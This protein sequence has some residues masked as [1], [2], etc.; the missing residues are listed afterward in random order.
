MGTIS[1]TLSGTPATTST[2]STPTYFAGVSTYSTQLQE[3]IGRAV[4]IASLPIQELTSQQTAL[5]GQATELTTLD[6]DFAAVQTAIQNISSA[7]GGA[8]MNSTVSNPA[9]ASVTVGD[10]ATQGEYSLDV[11]SIGAY[12][13]SLTGG[14]W[15]D[16]TDPKGQ[17]T[18][19]NLVVGANTHSFTPTDNSAETVAATINAQ[20]GDVVQATAV[21]VGSASSPDERISLQSV[22]LGPMDLDIQTPAGSSLQIAQPAATGYA[23][24]TSANTWDS[25]GSPSTY[26][27][28]VDGADYT[29]S[30][31]DNSAAQVAAAINAVSGNPVQASVVNLGTATSP[32]ERIQLQSTSAGVATVDLLDSSGNSLQ[33]QETPAAA[34]SAVSQTSGTWDSTPDPSGNPTQYILTVGSTTQTFTS[35]DTSATGVAAAINAL[36]GNPV[37]ATVV[38]LGTSSV[39]DYTIQLT[40]NTGSGDSP[41]LTASTPSGLQSQGPAGSLAQ[42]E[43]SNSGVTVSSDTQTVTIA[44]GTTVSL[45]GTG[46]TDITV[47]Q[48]ASTL[49]T[50][51]SGFADKYNA[52]VAE[53][54]KQYGQSGGPLQGQSIVHGLSQALSRMSTYYSSASGS[55]GMADLGFTLNDD[56]TLTYSP[57]NMMSTDLENSAGVVA[58]LGSA[59]G[60]GFLQAATN[61]MNIIETPTTGLL[62][63]TEAAV[64][65]QITDLGTSIA[66]KQAAVTQLQ[67]NLTN[68]MAQ[69]DAAI[70]SMQAQYSYMTSVFQA[71]QTADQMYANE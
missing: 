22:N 49:N 52:V 70:A 24:S 9:V 45:T 57:L 64:Q 50:A 36:S 43:V 65:S 69:A 51:L 6:T 66:A 68:Q 40:D 11:S 27:L 39:P 32:D 14:T 7:L 23:T 59:T 5:T 21:N 8:G 53:L 29:I 54:A 1:S 17:T 62:K 16:T 42:Y 67:T 4:S 10:G 25:S 63:S 38:D 31:T 3:V 56:G 46:T 30:P 12:A 35:A 33:Q 18:T 37:T 15:N 61:A 58:F 26:T 48:S 13:T 44:A 60:G 20:F 2:S 41:Q 55:L 47:T 71:Q 19:Y 28:A 34:G